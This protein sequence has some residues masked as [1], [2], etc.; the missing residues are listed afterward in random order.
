MRSTPMLTTVRAQQGHRVFVAFADGTAGEVDL[1]E[2]PDLGPVF[3]PLRDPGYFRRLRLSKEGN[4][5]VWPNGADIPPETL[6]EAVLRH[7]AQA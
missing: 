7:P 3:E 2:L 4:T 5:I 1:S 6:Y